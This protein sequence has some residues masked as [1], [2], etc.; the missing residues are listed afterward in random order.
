MNKS[1]QIVTV[2]VPRLP[3]SIDGLGDYGLN[4]AKQLQL[5]FGI[6]T[7]FIVGDPLWFGDTSCHGFKVSRLDTRSSS[8]LLSLLLA[9][10]KSESESEGE[11][12]VILHYVGY[13]YAKRGSPFWL[14]HAL[15]NWRNKSAKRKLITMFHE[16]FAF[17]PFWTS[18]FW[19]SPLQKF[20]ATRLG[21][22]SDYAITSQSSYALTLKQLTNS[23][24]P[25]I[26]VL[27]IFSNIGE[28]VS[29]P[30][31]INRKKQ[32]VIFGNRGPK[33]RLYKQSLDSIH[34]ICEKFG[35]TDI[36]DIGPSP[37]TNT[38]DFKSIN[39]VKMGTLEASEI[40]KILSESM[41][42]IVNY[43]RQYI[44]KSGIFA[45]YCSHGML[46]I[47]LDNQDLE[48]EADSSSIYYLM[49]NN[50]LEGLLDE[51]Q[52]QLISTNAYEWYLGHSL[53]VHAQIYYHV[54]KNA[55]S[56]NNE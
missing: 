24:H 47:I 56:K 11:H 29:F 3:P 26:P 18:Q 14:L 54:L 6:Q 42:G 50:K 9:K 38:L 7:E 13:G 33:A 46:P 5:D 4:L 8:A 17:G 32:I 22:L 51:E 23:K 35:I 16:L 34:L 15:E 28:P 43:P 36:L 44:F 27:S 52:A 31:L 49:K 25:E 19:T 41:I 12:I 1:N 45:S 21:R 2:I 30:N 10:S 48:I 55:M 39:F 37:E 20:I 40:S 53:K